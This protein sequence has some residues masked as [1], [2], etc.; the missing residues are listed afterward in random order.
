M[1][2]KTSHCCK[3]ST[4][5]SQAREPDRMIRIAISAEAFEASLGRSRSGS[6]SFE[7]KTNERGEN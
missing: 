4:P 7:N 5:P 2:I 3:R 6:M 1:T